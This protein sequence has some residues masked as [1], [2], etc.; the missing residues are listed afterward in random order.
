MSEIIKTANELKAGIPSAA[1]Q[2]RK[3]RGLTLKEVEKLSGGRFKAVVIGSYER[4]DRALSLSKAIDLAEIY[5][6]AIDQLLGIPKVDSKISGRLA[7][8]IPKLQASHAP[9]LTMIKHLA[10]TLRAMRGD[11]NRE[12]CTIR[13][14][15]QISLAACLGI[16]PA[17]LIPSLLALDVLAA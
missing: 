17:E 5:G 4:G 3:S 8:D 13:E 14:S 9:S 15:D 2:A 16:S 7:L 10:L 12:I 6:C 11:W 1:R